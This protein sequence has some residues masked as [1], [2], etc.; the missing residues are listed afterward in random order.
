M[1]IE[2]LNKWIESEEGMAWLEEKKTPLLK[3]RDELLEVNKALRA[4]LQEVKN[5]ANG[6]SSA[7]QQEREAVKKVVLDDKLESLMNEIGIGKRFRNMVK[8][9]LLESFS[10]EV[11][12]DGLSRFATVKS[13]EMEKPMRLDDYM[14]TKWGKDENG[15]WTDDV[16]D[17]VT[18]PIN[19]GGGAR[20]NIRSHVD[21]SSFDADVKAILDKI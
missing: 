21:E 14:R 6:A 16:K 9:E 19:S 18:A 7:L 13:E 2:E 5:S 20:G 1:N 17:I 4:D 3:K 11:Q 8:S 10:I 15:M 12:A